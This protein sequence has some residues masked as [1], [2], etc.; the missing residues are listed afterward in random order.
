MHCVRVTRRV[1][2]TVFSPKNRP[3][4]FGTTLKIHNQLDI[5]RYYIRKS[6]E[7]ICSSFNLVNNSTNIHLITRRRQSLHKRVC[8][9][10]DDKYSFFSCIF[11]C[12][13]SFYSYIHNFSQ[14][15][16]VSCPYRMSKQ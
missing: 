10:S 15:F 14:L 13:N 9:E 11:F 16:C 5:F 4:S 1:V 8:L 6:L 3:F 2:I 12:S 7:K